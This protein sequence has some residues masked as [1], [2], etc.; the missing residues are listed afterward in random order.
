MISD[1]GEFEKAR[2]LVDREYEHLIA[3]GRKPPDEI[4]LG[5][6]IEVPALIWQL[7]RLL[8]MTDFV[9]VGTNDL[10]Q[11]LF[12]ADRANMRVA[13]RY[14]PLN[15]AILRV[16]RQIV[17]SCTEHDVPLTLCGEMAS[18]PLEAM[19]LIGLGYRALSMAPAAIGPVKA[20]VLHA[21]RAAL[22][23]AILPMLDAGHGDL[24]EQLERLAE[25]Q[26]IEQ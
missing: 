2:R 23:R 16:L 8:P 6:M 19:T 15:I 13:H 22:Q 26:E 17:L 1:V 4:L 25:A 3:H 20:M 7:D 10:L 5:A 12:A 21:D 11:F 9:S 14:D 18:R 24:R